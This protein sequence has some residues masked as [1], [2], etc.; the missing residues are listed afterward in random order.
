MKLFFVCLLVIGVSQANGQGNKVYDA[1]YLQVPPVFPFGI[2]SCQ[3]FY[4]THFKGF[5]NVLDKVIANGDTAKYI[6][7]YFSFI[8]DKHGTAYNAHFDKIASTR[9]AK[10]VTVRP[11]RYFN[12]QYY[13]KVI[14]Y[15]I[16]KIPFWKPALLNGIPVDCRVE[17][18]IQFW[19]GANIPEY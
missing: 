2:D 15:M 19:V 14:K 10:S 6:R 17:D 11:I 1:K 13:E 16:A 18:Y 12:S 9:Y 7:V 5:D 4:F 3:R 8:I